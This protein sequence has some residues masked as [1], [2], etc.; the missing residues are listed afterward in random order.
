MASTIVPLI[1]FVP[2]KFNVLPLEIPLVNCVPD[3]FIT[4]V[5]ATATPLKFLISATSLIVNVLLALVIPPRLPPLI[6]PV[7]LPSIVKSAPVEPT[8]VLS[9][10]FE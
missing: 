8:L 7:P 10:T 5:F 6:T 1:V 4:P 9:P 2:L 3:T